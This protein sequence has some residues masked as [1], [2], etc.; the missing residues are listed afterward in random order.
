MI[1]SAIV[2]LTGCDFFD[3]IYNNSSNEQTPSES[4]TTED[5]IPYFTSKRFKTGD[6]VDMTSC[7]DFPRDYFISYSQSGH[8]INFRL[9]SF[10]DN[11]KNIVINVFFKNPGASECCYD[12]A[13]W[14]CNSETGKPTSTSFSFKPSS[15]KNNAKIDVISVKGYTTLGFKYQIYEDNSVY[16]DEYSDFSFFSYSYCGSN[17]TIMSDTYRLPISIGDYKVETFGYGAVDLFGFE[18]VKA[19]IFP[20][21]YLHI[22]WRAWETSKNIEKILYEGTEKY[23]REVRSDIVYLNPFY[24]S[25]E[26]PSE[27]GKYWRYVNNV[28]TIW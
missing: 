11:Y 17:E 4:S 1:M 16:N 5:K 8:Y 3:E 13:V 24:Y 10:T 25:E 27:K 21:N 12:T 26:Q 7:Y 2:C 6:W 23:A 15:V 28:P 14:P 9:K 22:N 20:I 18:N 19:I